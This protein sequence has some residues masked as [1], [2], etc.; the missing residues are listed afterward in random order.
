MADLIDAAQDYEAR[1]RE[2]AISAARARAYDPGPNMST[3][4]PCCRECGDPI[5]TPRLQAVPGVGLCID[6][7][8]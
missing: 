1:E 5:P 8:E 2:A 4:A 6:C 3:G 7:A